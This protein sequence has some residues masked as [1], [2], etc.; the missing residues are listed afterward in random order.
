[1]KKNRYDE[2]AL[3]KALEILEGYNVRTVGESLEA[4][5]FY[6][7]KCAMNKIKHHLKDPYLPK[8]SKQTYVDAFRALSDI[9][10][11]KLE[12]DVMGVN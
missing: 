6:H 4:R 1:M 3:L 9:S 12:K 5:A 7:L 10:F 11:D 8:S 2:D